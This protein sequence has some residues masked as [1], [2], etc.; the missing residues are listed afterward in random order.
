MSKDMVNQPTHY[1]SGGIECLDAIRAS[2]T[3]EA[4]KGFL[5]GNVLKYM[6]RYEKKFNPTEDLK[7]AQWYLK[8]LEEANEAPKSKDHLKTE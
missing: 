7:K 6:W 4:F 8:R 1:T 3:E 2:M 5:K